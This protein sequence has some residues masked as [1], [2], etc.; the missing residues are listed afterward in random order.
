[1]KANLYNPSVR[2]VLAAMCGDKSR[3]A[4]SLREIHY[5]AGSLREIH[6]EAGSLREIYYEAGSLREIHYFH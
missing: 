5:E 1:M 6:Y 2:F 3:T 4:G